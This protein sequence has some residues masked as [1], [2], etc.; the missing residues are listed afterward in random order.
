MGGVTNENLMVQAP[1][2]SINPII[3]LSIIILL[4]VLTGFLGFTTIND[5]AT[6]WLLFLSIMVV[7]FIIAIGVES[8]V[9]IGVAVAM[10]GGVASILEFFVVL[11]IMTD[12][13]KILHTQ[14]PLFTAPLFLALVLSNAFIIWVYWLGG[15]QVLGYIS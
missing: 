2:I 12:S 10:V 13:D 7:A 15:A 11:G 1:S 9:E 5:D 6:V 4:W 3:L 8:S 14:K